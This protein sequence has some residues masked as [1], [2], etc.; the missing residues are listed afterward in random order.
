MRDTVLEQHL[1]REEL[2]ALR[3]R[4]TGMT[5]FQ[6]SWIMIFLCLVM[7]NWQLRYSYTEWPPPGVEKM[8]VILP[9]FATLILLVSVALARRGLSAIRQDGRGAFL[10]LWRAVIGLGAAFVALMVFEWLR[11]PMG[12]QYGTVFR[13]M[14]GF[15]GFHALV[16]GLYMA[17]VYRAAAAGQYG[18][19]DFWAI[20]AGVKLWYFVAFAWLLFYAVLY[21]I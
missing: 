11:V 21:W 9:S 4:R 15:H 7:V 20:E 19:L 5:I 18:S 14:I 10:T 1:T 16:I 2:L 17:G 6:I 3:N 8:G 13:L 12:T